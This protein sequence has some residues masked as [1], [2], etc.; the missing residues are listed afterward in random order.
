MFNNTIVF[1]HF[2]LMLDDDPQWE[3]RTYQISDSK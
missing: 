3:K 1:L 2:H